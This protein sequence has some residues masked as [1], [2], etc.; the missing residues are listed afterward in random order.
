M[1]KCARFSARIPRLNFLESRKPPG[2]AAL[3]A[4]FPNFNQFLS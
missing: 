2:S 4:T 3:M 1:E